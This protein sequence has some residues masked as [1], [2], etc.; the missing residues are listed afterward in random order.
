MSSSIN[1]VSSKNSELERN[2]KRLRFVKT[3]AVISLIL[4][5]LTSVLV[6]IINLSLPISDVK[7]GQK[8]T[9]ASIASL[10][11]K[12]ATFFLIKDRIVNISSILS[13]RK[14]YVDATNSVF[15][16]LPSGLS[17]DALDVETGT[18]LLTVSGN[19]LLPMNQFLDNLIVLG[20]SK[21]VIKNLNIQ[22][23]ILNTRN[24]SYSLTIQADIL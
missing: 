1:L 6:F 5:A 18:M 14:S 7:K 19:S 23:L 10:H 16:K 13:K 3:F 9:L 12:Q 21:K 24:G 20:Q 22:S 4:V 11:S 15:G 8:D 2:L 17:A